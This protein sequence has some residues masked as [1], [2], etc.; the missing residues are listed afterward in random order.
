MKDHNQVANKH[1]LRCSTIV[2]IRGITNELPPHTYEEAKS[3]K[4]KKT[5]C[6]QGVGATETLVHCWWECKSLE[7][8]RRKIQ[9]FLITPHMC[10]AWDPVIPCPGTCP[11][12]MQA[13]A[14]QEIGTNVF[15]AEYVKAT[16]KEAQRSIRARMDK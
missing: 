2:V 8:R 1:V 7:P 14:Y 11:K 13:H 15:T 3:K 16:I 6:W 10:P 4:T 9:Q 12:E 5:K